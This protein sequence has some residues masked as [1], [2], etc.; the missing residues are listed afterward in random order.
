MTPAE[1][2]HL[3][4]LTGAVNELRSQFKLLLAT[5]DGP[6]SITEEID[7]L[8]G[9]RIFY[10]L[11]GRQNFDIN[12]L[13]TRGDPV[14]FFVSQDGPFVM[15]HYPLVTWK[16]NLPTTATNLGKWSPPTSWPLPIQQMNNQDNI[17][18]SYEFFDGGSQ[19]A[20]NNETAAP[21][22]SRPDNLA[23]LPVPTLFAPNANIQ[24]I[25]TYE[26]IFFDGDVQVPTEG[27]QLVVTL[28]G[29]RIV[30]L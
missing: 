14:S 5:D 13:G 24:F 17:D 3:R 7:S 29:Y 8:P 20:F 26:D 28:P 30:N 2:A 27:G 22:F 19:R 18:L 6:R 15:T 1:S 11:S 10:N 9:R 4:K 12:Q 16:P 25:P 21:L 23:P